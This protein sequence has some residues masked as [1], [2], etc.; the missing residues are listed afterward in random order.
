MN[1][2]E[3][4]SQV[5]R[6][7]RKWSFY[8]QRSETLKQAFN[9]WDDQI[10]IQH[11]PHY[12]RNALEHWRNTSHI[13]YEHYKAFGNTCLYKSLWHLIAS[14]FVWKTF[15]H[16]HFHLRFAF[17]NALKLIF[18]VKNYGRKWKIDPIQWIIS[19]CSEKDSGASEMNHFK[20]W[21]ASEESF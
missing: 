12:T 4:C 11:N 20:N 13:S 14:Q 16:S 6:S 21:P 7:I 8:P 18:E 3:Y 1:N 9:C 5:V 10:T 19:I 15:N 17:S 2:W